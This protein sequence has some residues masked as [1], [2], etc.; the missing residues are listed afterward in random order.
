MLERKK[1]NRSII[2]LESSTLPPLHPQLLVSQQVMEVNF[3][4]CP[5][6]MWTENWRIE[7]IMGKHGCSRDISDLAFMLGE[8]RGNITKGNVWMRFCNLWTHMSQLNIT[9]RLNKTKPNW[10]LFKHTCSGLPTVWN[11]FNRMFIPLK[12]NRISVIYFLI[13]NN[14]VL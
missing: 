13:S 14:Y 9:F 5:D 11:S 1:G 7:E 4:C 10:L 8:A 3:S 2:L 12:P 6:R